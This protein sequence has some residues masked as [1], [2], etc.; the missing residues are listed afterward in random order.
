[1]TPTLLAF[2]T[3]T[4]L[5]SVALLA[6][7]GQMHAHEAAGGA[8]ASATLIPT[9]ER[10]LADAGVALA[11]LDAIVFGRGPGAF[12][13]LRTACSVAQGLAL[14]A[15]KRVLP[16]DTLM[17]LADDAR[18]RLAPP[19]SSSARPQRT[20]ALLDARMNE[21][22]AAQ[23][24]HDGERWHAVDA[25]MLTTA[26]ALN[27]RWRA[28]P[29]EVVAGN[30]L[31]A[32]GDRLATGTALRVPDA[33]P[34]A[35]ALLAVAPALIAQGGLVDAALALPLYVREKVAQTTAER[36]AARAAKRVAETA[37]AGALPR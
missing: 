14:G 25:P 13:G 22:Y 32:F 30:A 5:L 35:T 20:W 11:D 24:A 26:E 37:E 9:I 15:G 12:T 4:E 7:G 36:D 19:P 3:A 27:E 16:V 10:L 18:R 6:S 23:Y 31:D 33:L 21:I 29:P 17:A 28:A 2:D 8:L 1:M 34:R